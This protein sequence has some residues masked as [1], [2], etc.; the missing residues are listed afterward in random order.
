ME[1]QTQGKPLTDSFRNVYSQSTKGQKVDMPMKQKWGV[2][3]DG[4][5]NLKK[6]S[7][8]WIRQTYKQELPFSEVSAEGA[9]KIELTFVLSCVG[10]R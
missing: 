7:F 6:L 9:Q 4:I 5:P 10:F 3:E 8:S 1:C 2:G